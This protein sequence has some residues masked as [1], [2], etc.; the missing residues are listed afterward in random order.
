M[1]QGLLRPFKCKKFILLQEETVTNVTKIMARWF[2]T[3][4]GGRSLFDHLG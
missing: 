2:L 1:L 3:G 4:T